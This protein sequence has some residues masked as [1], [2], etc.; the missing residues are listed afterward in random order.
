[1]TLEGVGALKVKN[2]KY[3]LLEPVALTAS[4]IRKPHKIRHFNDSRCQRTEYF[5]ADFAIDGA[6]GSRWMAND[7]D[8]LPTL[9]ID[10]GK[11]KT[12][13]ESRIAFVR[14]TAG[15]A[16]H[17]EGSTDGQTWQPC[18]GHDDVQK[19]SPHTDVIN[20][21]FRYLRVTIT[22]GVKG[23]WEWEVN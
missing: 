3:K 5:V 23:V 1:M 18:G 21:N 11:T 20:K 4:S 17:L 10:L 9:T 14:P 22:E 8:S 2:E 6:N 15:H 16:Y 19:R 7:T 13:H 12:I